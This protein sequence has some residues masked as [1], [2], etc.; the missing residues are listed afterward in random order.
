MCIRD[1]CR[2]AGLHDAD[3]TEGSGVYNPDIG[4]MQA[5][6]TAP[7]GAG[8]QHAEEGYLGC[9]DLPGHLASSSIQL[10][11]SLDRMAGITSAYLDCCQELTRS[12]LGS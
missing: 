12:M 7:P 1:R 2:T 10:G 3:V 8:R 11:T 6:R 5:R 4:V 9:R